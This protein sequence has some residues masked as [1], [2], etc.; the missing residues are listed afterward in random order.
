MP[1]KKRKNQPAFRENMK[2]FG[3]G[4]LF[5]H[6]IKRMGMKQNN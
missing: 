1:R 2:K 4:R 5:S 6:N 3:I